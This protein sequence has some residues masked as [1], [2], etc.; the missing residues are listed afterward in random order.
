MI[1]AILIL[2]AF[3]TVA[4]VAV[5][6]VPVPVVSASDHTESPIRAG[7]PILRTY[8]EQRIRGMSRECAES[9]NVQTRAT[10]RAGQRCERLSKGYYNRTSTQPEKR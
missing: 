6:G 3:L 10:A 4:A 8:P 9:G 7:I 5:M 1:F 2:C